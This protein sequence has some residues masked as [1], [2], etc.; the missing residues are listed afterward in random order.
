[1]TTTTVR[2]GDTAFLGHPKALGYLAFT[3]AWERFSY[4]GMN[5]LLALYMVNQLFLPGHVEN[6]VGLPALRALLGVDLSPQALAIAIAGA[7]GA[8]VYLTP[9]LG[10]LLADTLLGRTPTIILGA[11]LMATGH[12][13]MAFEQPFLLAL[14]CLVIGSGCFKGNI[15]SQVGSLYPEGDTRRAD[16]FQI[17]YL[18]I[19]AG[20][21]VSPLVVAR[22]AH[23]VGWHWGFGAA[24][25]GML[26]SIVIYLSGRR[27]FPSDPPLRKRGEIKADR[28]AMVRSDWNRVFLLALMV[29]L[30]AA[31]VL[32]NQQIFVTY[33]VWAQQS[34]DLQVF[35]VKFLAEDLVS[36]DAFVSVGCLAGMV[37][38]WRVW[39]KRFK[40]PDEFGKI[41]I[42]CLFGALG[43]ACL[44]I[45]AMVTPP[46]EK[47][48]VAWLLAFHLLNDIGFA[49]VLPVSLALFARAAPQAIA[50]SVIG[51][52]YLFLFAGNATA[53]WLGTKLEQMGS[54]NFWLMHGAIVA[55]A[56]LVILAIAPIF[57]RVL[58][59]GQ[60]PAPA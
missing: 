34:V 60:G 58:N 14:L 45:G 29:P 11:L 2:E 40:E 35:G 15:A 18:A 9:L 32:G 12:F 54:V 6:V 10:G 7:Y 5:T 26:I 24:G 21:I 48:S 46:G 4:Y 36:A 38:F 33:L 28:P 17:F 41:V 42:G 1:M 39:A 51:I 3:E 56:A 43:V 31:S 59:A 30:L 52:Y 47:V 49:N 53:G 8:C 22:L 13:L 57:R 44:G 16:A 55:G 20:V 19:N 27:L 25:V 23:G 37:I 50:G